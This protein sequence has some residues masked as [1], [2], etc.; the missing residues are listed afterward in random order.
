MQVYRLCWKMIRQ[1]WKPIIIYA[2]VFL[3]FVLLVSR[4]ASNTNSTEESRIPV[5]LINEGEDTALT[6]A[7]REFMSDEVSYVPIPPLQYKLKKDMFYDG[8][9]CVIRLSKSLTEDYDKKN[10][11]K[12]V[13][14]HLIE[15]D[16][17]IKVELLINQF[18]QLCKEAQSKNEPIEKV[19]NAYKENRQSDTEISSVGNRTTSHK[20]YGLY[21]DYLSYVLMMSIMSYV[22]LQMYYF[23]QERIG[24]RNAIAPISVKNVY[25]QVVLASSVSGLMIAAVYILIGLLLGNIKSINLPVILISF[26]ILLYT[27]F[28]VAV[29]VLLGVL[30]KSLKGID[31]W[32]Q[33]FAVGSCFLCGVFVE[34]NRLPDSILKLSVYLPT[35]WF[36]KINNELAIKPGLKFRD[37]QTFLIEESI[38]LC[39]TLILFVVSFIILEKKVNVND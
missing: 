23:K 14:Y 24:I 34:Q 31:H 5:L 12:I 9:K 1:S 39:Y 30:I 16:D 8:I 20:M 28:C 13:R 26:N 32:E 38:I 18:L 25:R 33:F 37:Y 29:S 7:F 27:L 17:T 21:A 19:V 22:V 11:M 36:V 2:I 10:P 3:A 35:Y 4:G 6:D 15:S